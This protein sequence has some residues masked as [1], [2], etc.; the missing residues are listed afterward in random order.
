MF[1]YINTA[2]IGAMC[3]LA[4]ACSGDEPMTDTSASGSGAAVTIPVNFSVGLNDFDSSR[5]S[6]DEWPDGACVLMYSATSTQQYGT[7]SYSAA[8]ATWTATL[9]HQPASGCDKPCRL[10]YVPGYSAASYAEATTIISTL[11]TVCNYATEA[12]YD[13]EDEK[14]DLFGVLKP[15]TGRLR[16]R[17]ETSSPWKCLRGLQNFD[18]AEMELVSLSDTRTELPRMTQAEDGLWYTPYLYVNSIP[19]FAVSA[20][21]VYAY[22]DDTKQLNPGQ[23]VVIDAPAGGESN[24]TWS[25]KSTSVTGQLSQVNVYSNNSKTV[26]TGDYENA[27]GFR[28]YGS[29]TWK[30]YSGSALSYTSSYPYPFH[31]VVMD[32]NGYTTRYNVASRISSGTYTFDF[33]ISSTSISKIYLEE[34]HFD[35]YVT[36]N[37]YTLEYK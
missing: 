24:A 37:S 27:D 36:I 8:T 26:L 9:T 19:R 1:K 31:F 29:F 18:L 6:F 17:A 21:F 16:L 15:L 12:T 13:F 5:S 2:I 7:L 32:K 11:A 25:R 22:N 30:P 33:N 4:G 35:V 34:T 14:L 3:L 28:F 10:Y 20:A 23:S